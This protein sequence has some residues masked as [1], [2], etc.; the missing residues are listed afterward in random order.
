MAM[1][2]TIADLVTRFSVSGIA[3]VRRQVAKLGGDVSK[4]L[5]KAAVKAPLKG[6]TV[7]ASAATTALKGTTKAASG[8]AKVVAGIGGVGSV[9]GVGG[10]LIAVRKAVE[11]SQGYIQELEKVAAGVDMPVPELS[12]FAAYA[13][14]FGLEMEDI[15][16]AMQQFYSIAGQ[17]A[18]GNNE[19]ART[20]ES[21]GLDMTKAENRMLTMSQLFKKF[22]KQMSTVTG[23]KK[24]YFLSTIFGDDDATRV[25]R[26]VDAMG[27]LGGGIANL[28]PGDYSAEYLKNLSEMPD[29]YKDSVEQARKSGALV[30][31]QDLQ[32]SK[33]LKANTIKLRQSFRGLQMEIFRAFGEPFKAMMNVAAQLITKHRFMITAYL[34]VSWRRFVSLVHDAIV[35]FGNKQPL[36][37]IQ[38]T[39]LYTAKNVMGAI[40]NVIK[41]LGH[42]I[43][44]AYRAA[45]ALVLRA[46]GKTIVEYLRS[47][48]AEDIVRVIDLIVVWLKYGAAVI[49]DFFDVLLGRDQDIT[50]GIGKVMKGWRDAVVAWLLNAWNAVQPVLQGVWTA[51]TEIYAGL[52]SGQIDLAASSWENF[53]AMIRI[54]FDYVVGFAQAFYT[55][56]VLQQN[57]VG[58]FAWMNTVRDWIIMI[59]THLQVALQWFN[60]MFSAVEKFLA[61]W[62]IDLRATLLFLGLLQLTG[63]GGLLMLVFK[64]LGLVG[65]GLKLLW[66]IFSSKVAVNVFLGSLNAIRIGLSTVG[67]FVTT[68]ASTIAT[69][70]A[71]AFGG[72][73]PN[74]IKAMSGLGPAIG[75]FL[76]GAGVL[77]VAVA[78]GAWVG[79]QIGAALADFFFPVAKKLPEIWPKDKYGRDVI[80]AGVTP[81]DTPSSAIMAASHTA[82]GMEYASLMNAGAPANQHL[83]DI[84]INVAGQSYPAKM[85]PDVFEDIKRRRAADPSIFVF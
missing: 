70:L 64:G 26:I 20:F 1:K 30:T 49:D 29:P 82:G 3:D 12:E 71:A 28:P 35:I 19:Y 74:A 16:Q 42:L 32:L 81:R 18:L 22:S 77:G 21:L 25:A 27:R 68:F 40:W 79:S 23:Q 13:E 80:P 76:L 45:D 14:N 33:D 54:A 85:S 53:G 61:Q 62:G 59:W 50:T 46:T 39:W 63:A 52:N 84:N 55:V 7:G 15:R 51:I 41:V 69:E 78:A 24:A 72:V 8:L 65:D 10:Q 37:A 75:R 73:A 66:T 56:F 44:I 34:V 11:Q 4:T 60:A 6:L 43:V 58:A 17:A 48:K 57:A 83:G 36:I 9:A 2:R 47:L 5:A 38:N 67:V 31:E